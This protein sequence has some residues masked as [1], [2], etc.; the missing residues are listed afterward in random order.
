MR[1]LPRM[2]AG[3][4]VTMPF[5]SIPID[6]ISALLWYGMGHGVYGISGVTISPTNYQHA[7]RRKPSMNEHPSTRSSKL[8]MALGL[9]GMLC[10]AS[11]QV[12]TDGVVASAALP[13][14]GPAH[15]AADRLSA[16]R[17]RLPAPALTSQTSIE[18][19][20]VARRSVRNYAPDPL[21]LAQCAQLLWAAQGV[22]HPDGLRTAPSAGAL[23]PLEVFLAAADVTGLPAGVYRYQPHTHELSPIVYDDLRF[24]LRRAV[25]GQ[26]PVQDAPAVI[27]IA[28]VY[29]RT[30]GKYGD[31][32]IT[33]VQMEA[34]AA[35]QNITLQAVSL[36]LGAVYIG[37]FDEEA[38]KQVLSLAPDEEPLVVMPVRV[39]AP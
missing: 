32:G 9:S 10:C 19:A 24:D 38:V 34:A 14:A 15:T 16:S 29:E 28:G 36:R 26:Q 13:T 5:P 30:M 27:V 11:C 25:V 18:Q 37:A 35:A 17:I 6:G 22:T 23:Y 1:R 7:G 21:T 4:S 8:L 31:R 12:A 20:L 39:P 3:A 2:R 33:Y